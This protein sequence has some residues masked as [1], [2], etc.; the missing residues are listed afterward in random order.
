ME[1]VMLLLAGLCLIGIFSILFG[2][3]VL[4]QSLDRIEKHLKIGE[5]V[6]D[7]PPYIPMPQV[8]RYEGV[9]WRR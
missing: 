4:G 2:L 5:C 9:E 8:K 3:Y 1:S 6:S 7:Y